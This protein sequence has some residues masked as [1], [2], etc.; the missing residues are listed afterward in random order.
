MRRSGPPP[1]GEA[2]REAWRIVLHA[3]ETAIDVDDLQPY[4]RGVLADLHAHAGRQI[5][6][7]GPGVPI[8]GV[9]GK[10]LE[11]VRAPGSVFELGRFGVT[12]DALALLAS[13]AGIRHVAD[14]ER[15]TDDEPRG[16]DR[17]GPKRLAAIRFAVRQYR[18]TAA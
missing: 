10:P 14:V 18:A 16:I 17:I 4:D 11:G 7:Y 1:F 8:T 6:V 5:G 15:R 2:E 12:A 3:I 9:P 13:R